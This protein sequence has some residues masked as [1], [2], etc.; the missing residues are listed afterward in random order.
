MRTK[1]ASAQQHAILI[2][3]D[4]RTVVDTFCALLG[5]EGYE[6]H[7]A[8]SGE[9]ALRFLQQQAAMAPPHTLPV[10]LVILDVVLPAMG[11]LEVCRRIKGD[12]WLRYMPV[13]MVTALNSIQDQGEAIT[14]G[15]DDYVTKP[16]NSEE[17]LIRVRALLRIGDLQRELLA[18]NA[19]LYALPT[20]NESLLHSMGDGLLAVDHEGRITLANRAALTMLRC[21]PAESEG[22]K[23]DALRP[24]YA[25]LT[26]VVGRVLAEKTPRAMEEV[27]VRLDEE[28]VPLRVRTTLLHDDG[29]AVSGV[30]AL[31]EDLRPIK[32]MEAKQRRLDRLTVLNQMAA[33]IAHEIRNPLQTLS[34]GM[35][36]LRRSLEPDVD[37]EE[38]LQRLQ[39]QVDRISQIVNEFLT[40]ARPPKLNRVPCDMR[41][42]LERA[43]ELA[44][45]RLLECGVQVHR[46]YAAELPPAELDA[47][48]LERALSNLILNAAD[49]MPEGGDLYLS[50]VTRGVGGSAPGD[51]AGEIEVQVRDTGAGMPPEIAERVFD[52]FFTTKPKGIGLGLTITQRI[53]EEHGGRIVVA[54][55]PGAGTT[56]TVTLPIQERTN[57]ARQ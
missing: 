20:F 10:D 24:E 8:L 39:R 37:T 11:G 28:L 27:H 19:Q 12:P 42:V 36:Y 31:L 38:T 34:L 57:D 3:D 55:L 6:I 33:S 15:A 52:P 48:A 1:L 51:C 54:S 30:I 47:E 7:A 56:F 46:D 29:G 14:A 41:D 26:A 25:E 4:D 21:S 32:E 23:L 9:E 43:L 5:M 16:F 18:R 2:V 53:I 40:V 49:A 44:E 17:L 13:L 22:R 50:A 45:P 35:R